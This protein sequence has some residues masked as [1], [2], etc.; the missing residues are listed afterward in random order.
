MASI[1]NTLLCWTIL[2]FEVRLDLFVNA[3]QIAVYTT[4]DASQSPRIYIDKYL[5]LGLDEIVV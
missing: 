2:V 1:P 4:I 3:V 5:Y